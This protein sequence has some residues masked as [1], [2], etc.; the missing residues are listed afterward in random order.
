MF[1]KSL[2]TKNRPFLEAAIALHQSGRIPANSYLLDLD[3]MLANARI[4]SNEARRLGL[5][6]FAMT[7][8]FGRNPPALD[9]L[10]E[11]GIERFVAVDMAC[12]RP[13]RDHDH[14]VA[15]IG[16]LSQIPRAEA[17]RAAAM[18]PAFWTVFSAKKAAEAA[19]AA[20]AEGYQQA[21][22]ARI[23][24]P[25]DTFYPGHEGGFAVAE[26]E[27]AIE[28]LNRNPGGRFAGLTTFPALLFDETKGAVQPTPNLATLE[29]TANHLARLN[30]QGVEINAPGTTS[31]QVLQLLADS[32]ATQVEPGHGLTGSTPLH[33]VA[34]LPEKPA[35]L[36]LTEVSHLY[37]GR[38][39]CFGGG[40]YIDPVFAPYPLKAFVGH[41]PD[42]A[43]ARPID[44]SIPEPGMIDYY[45]QVYPGGTDQLEVGDTVIFGFRA[46]AF[47]TRAF[48]V[49]VAGIATGRPE[50][51]GIWTTN[52]CRA[53]W[54]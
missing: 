44:A 52:G 24:A 29:A 14:Q 1:L 41:D 33:A 43:L 9:A 47:V 39:Y 18:R 37:Q 21:L 50:V 46:Q 49:P 2:S 25:Q 5:A 32:G 19:Q 51:R 16:H 12:A 13:I 17:P 3:T 34:E 45:G 54:P 15:H 4:M 36:Y 22:L 53:E 42:G 6:V 7:K 35:M 20:A 23:F 40:L 27:T 11:G 38:A 10:K 28:S 8:Q 30:V 48:I 26:I 31:T